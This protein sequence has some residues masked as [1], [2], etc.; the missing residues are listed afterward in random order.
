MKRR[1]NRTGRISI[2]LNR[3]RVSI[4]ESDNGAPPTFDLDLDLGGLGFPSDSVVRV[5]AWRGNSVQRWQYGTVAALTPPNDS[6]RRLTEVSGSSR[7][8]VM[9]V[10][11]DGSGLLLGHAHNI[12]PARAIGS[13]LPIRE[14]KEIGDEIWRVDFGDDGIGTPELLLNADIGGISQIVR[15]DAAFR[16]LVMPAVFRMIL[17]HIVLIVRQDPEDLENPLQGWFDLAQDLVP[18]EDIPYGGEYGEEFVQTAMQWID[19]VVEA[20]AQ[21]SLNDA[22]ETYDSAARR[23]R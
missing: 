5:E 18:E 6:Q 14:T 19:R 11:G 22:A 17:A 7:F 4:R 3:A 8:R 16:T 9:V 21:F 2:P 15:G 13:L 12:R 10:A 23:L 20:F 1:F